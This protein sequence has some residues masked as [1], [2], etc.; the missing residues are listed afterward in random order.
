MHDR[1]TVLL[2]VGVFAL[3][4]AGCTTNTVPKAASSREQDG[5]P[6]T[7]QQDRVTVYVEGMTK[8]QGIT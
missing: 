6:R 2:A 3:L 8:V 7:A 4:I 5:K 1:R